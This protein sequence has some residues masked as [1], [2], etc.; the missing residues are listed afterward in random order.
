M[1]K[2]PPPERRRTLAEERRAQKKRPPLAPGVPQSDQEEAA[3]STTK[4][5]EKPVIEC[6]QPHSW[7]S[8]VWGEW[9][10]GENTPPRHAVPAHLTPHDCDASKKSIAGWLDSVKR[11]R[12]SGLYGA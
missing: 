1:P 5:A 2:R 9:R 12:K 7:Y 11:R 6:P 3:E 8:Q 10:G 4:W